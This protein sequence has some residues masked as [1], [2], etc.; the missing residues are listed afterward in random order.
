MPPTTT[1]KGIG[2]WHKRQLSGGKR[3]LQ[4]GCARAGTGRDPEFINLQPEV[5]QRDPGKASMCAHPGFFP[6]LFHA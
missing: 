4:Q 1:T 3:L 5:D 6:H 2:S